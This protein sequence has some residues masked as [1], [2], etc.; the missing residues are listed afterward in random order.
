[1]SEAVEY[2]A[3]PQFVTLGPDFSDPVAPA[4]F[5][6]ATGRYWN[7]AW[8]A[9]LGLEGLTPEDRVRHF[10][11][12]EA[13]PDN[14]PE[15]LA[16]RYHGH[17]FRT[18]NPDLGDGR[19]FLFAQL[20]DRENR[21]LDFATKGSG[22]TP[23]SRN[24]DGRLTLKGAVREILAANMLEA[25]G[26]YTSKPFAVFET[27]EALERNDEPSPT[28]SAVLTRLGHSHMRFGTF[29]R[30]AFENSPARIG[31]LIEHCL[32]L[33]YPD[34]D[35]G[36]DPSSALLKAVIESNAKLVAGWMAA[37]FVHGVLNTDNLNVTGESFDYGPWRFL[38]Y[39]E[40]GFTAAYFDQTGLYAYGRQPEAVFWALQQFAGA[41]ALAGDQKQLLADLNT[42]P[43]VYRVALLDAFM[44]RFGVSSAG[45]DQDEKLVRAY[46][47]F[48]QDSLM[49]WEQ[50]IFDHFCGEAS[51]ARAHARG[52]HGDTYK[53]FR[54]QLFDREP[55]L[56]ARLKHRIFKQD[57]PVS[58]VIEEVE[59]VWDAIADTDDWAPL[60]RL[61]DDVS[62]IGEGYGLGAG[63]MGFIQPA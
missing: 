29:Q 1:M 25:L 51:F 40:P 46:L 10:Q 18:Y 50:V 30:H 41:L 27:G 17:Q 6:Q 31:Q 56:P 4:V 52:Y 11:R 57:K 44:A 22:Q 54:D 61:L 37:G 2:K 47:E 15:A 59:R 45:R 21:L 33:Y 20:R 36:D 14:Q 13:L 38:P 49:P 42:F 23:W 58:M 9:E 16:M 43:A 39:Y 32:E 60:N 3:D 48:M 12:F 19:G 35:P 5:P 63:R 24:G 55:V 8:A 53:A 34:I 7:A 28:R 26:V 62:A